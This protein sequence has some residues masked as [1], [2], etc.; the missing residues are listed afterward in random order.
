M[1]ITYIVVDDLSG[2]HNSEILL[3][4]SGE[5]CA[6]GFSNLERDIGCALNGGFLHLGLL[7]GHVDDKLI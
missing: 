5:C 2:Y 1:T 7:V 4:G 3:V 6:D